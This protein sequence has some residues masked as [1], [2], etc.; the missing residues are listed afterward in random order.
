MNSV[1]SSFMSW[2][3]Y[4]IE[5]RIVA[6]SVAEYPLESD[7][8]AGGIWNRSIALSN[9]DN[10]MCAANKR[11][12]TRKQLLLISIHPKT[13][14]STSKH[15]WNSVKHCTLCDAQV[16]VIIYSLE[17]Q[18]YNAAELS[19]E[20]VHVRNHIFMAFRCFRMYMHA[21]R[22]TRFNCIA[23]NE[24]SNWTHSRAIKVL[25]ISFDTLRQCCAKIHADI[26]KLS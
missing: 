17:T 15:E 2:L 4:A 8:R 5:Y 16:W 23:I 13:A 19:A 14:A 21:N 6:F 10:M 7:A 18:T 3:N 20:R 24:F 26:Y 11:G 9:Y 22:I 25:C 1:I 12:K